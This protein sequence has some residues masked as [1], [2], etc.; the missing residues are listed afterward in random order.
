M[1]DCECLSSIIE[2]TPAGIMCCNI[3]LQQQ[4]CSRLSTQ[5]KKSDYPLHNVYWCSFLGLL[6]FMNFLPLFSFKWTL[7]FQERQIWSISSMY[8]RC[9]SRSFR[10]GLFLRFHIA[11][12]SCLTSTSLERKRVMLHEELGS[13]QFYR[14]IKHFLC[15]FF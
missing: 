9:I 2:D 12:F 11:F 5:S 8:T 13:S 6:V 10:S 15:Y 3:S 7:P 4:C 1:C 14:W